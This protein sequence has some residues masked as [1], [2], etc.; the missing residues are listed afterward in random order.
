MNRQAYT[1]TIPKPAPKRALAVPVDAEGLERLFAAWQQDTRPERQRHYALLWAQAMIKAGV[2]FCKS[3]MS[4]GGS[5]E[6]L[7]WA[8]SH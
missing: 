5:R 6:W 8:E 3:D 7:A 4:I 2:P 1:L